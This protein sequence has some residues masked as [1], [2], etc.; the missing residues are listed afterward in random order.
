MP[1]LEI[2]DFPAKLQAKYRFHSCFYPVRAGFTHELNNNE[3]SYEE[4]HSNCYQQSLVKYS[5]SRANSQEFPDAI[6]IPH[7]QP[8]KALRANSPLP[9]GLDRAADAHRFGR[10]ALFLL[11]N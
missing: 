8:Q 3:V 5:R 1:F 9:P 11:E 4:S 10:P 6:F 7:S 2:R